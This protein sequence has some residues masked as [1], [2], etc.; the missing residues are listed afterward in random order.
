ML[1]VDRM[2]RTKYLYAMTIISTVNLIE[3]QYDSEFLL[4]YWTLPYV[5]GCIADMPLLARTKAVSNKNVC[6]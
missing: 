2:A 5:N 4:A 1:H 6:F 3:W